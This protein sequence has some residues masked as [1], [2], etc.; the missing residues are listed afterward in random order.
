[1]RD[2]RDGFQQMRDGGGAF[3]ARPQVSGNTFA[4]GANQNAGNVLCDKPSTR[5]ARPPGGGSSISFGWNGEDQMPGRRPPQSQGRDFGQFDAPP[6]P[7]DPSRRMPQGQAWDGQRPGVQDNYLS[8]EDEWRQGG[9]PP[10]QQHRDPRDA[11]GRWNRGPEDDFSAD[12]RRFGG[13]AA[14][15]TWEQQMQQMDEE[16]R[17]MRMMQQ[18]DQCEETVMPQHAQ[19]FQQHHQQQFQPDFQQQ[20]PPQHFTHGARGQKQSANAFATGSNQNCGNF[21]TSTPTTRVL[22][23]PGGGSNFSFGGGDEPP[24]SRRQA[25]GRDGQMQSSAGG[26]GP[27]PGYGPAPGR[28]MQD[29]GY[30]QGAGRQMQDQGGQDLGNQTQDYG[31]GPGPG[32]QMQDQGYGAD[33]GMQMQDQGYGHG[34]ACGRGQPQDQGFEQ[35]RGGPARDDGYGMNRQQCPPNQVFGQ[36]QRESSNNYACGNNQNC[37]NMI[38]DRPTTRVQRPPGGAS[39]LTLG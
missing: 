2:G 17:Q 35:G 21:L 11:D 12:P 18:Q 32:R 36:R 3:G 27:D 8:P 31:Y 19:Q 37:G 23:P 39:S 10:S 30:G 34:R 24:P 6:Y 9:A 1:M 16:T 5:V 25:S 7:D 14:D 38:S 15:L 13:D 29:Q 33:Y 20:G 22:Q 28:Q 4:C 26:Q